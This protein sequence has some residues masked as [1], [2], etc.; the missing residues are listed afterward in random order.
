MTG[1]VAALCGVLGLSQCSNEVKPN[2]QVRW[3]KRPGVSVS[4]LGAVVF[5]V[6]ITDVGGRHF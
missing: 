6:G 3:G 5:Y 4:Y 1:V 2:L